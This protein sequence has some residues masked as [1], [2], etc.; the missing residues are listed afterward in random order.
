MSGGPAKLRQRI[1]E[2]DALRLYRSGVSHRVIAEQLG[3]RVEQVRGLIE[4][5]ERFEG[6]PLPHK[7]ST[8]PAQ[9]EDR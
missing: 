3:C 4:R 8:P 2:Q 6:M 9:G 7:G 5:G 1:R